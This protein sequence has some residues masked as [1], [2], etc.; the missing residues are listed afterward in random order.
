MMFARFHRPP[1]TSGK[2]TL[3]ALVSP[4]KTSASQ[5]G[6]Q[7]LKV[8]EVVYFLKL[9]E[10]QK[11]SSQSTYYWRT[12]QRCLIEE[13]ERFSER[14]PKSGLM[15]NGTAYKLPLL[16]RPT[17]VTGSSFWPTPQAADC[18]DRGNL[19]NPSIQRRLAKGKQVFLSM[20][21]SKNSGA[22]NPTWVEWLMGFPEGWT[23]L[24]ASVTP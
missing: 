11:D 7:E 24:D 1:L 13:W 14:W 20:C 18:R 8:I 23:D 12:S 5:A 4:V 9:C 2:L 22:L 10:L 15:L 17:D 6:T 19:S 3:F 21:V 16:V